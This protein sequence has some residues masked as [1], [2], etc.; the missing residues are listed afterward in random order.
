ME[1]RNRTVMEMARR[2]LKEMKLPAVLW[3]EAVRHTVYVLKKF[4]TR[5]LTGVTPYEAWYRK[6]PDIGHIRV[7]GCLGHIKVPS[8]STQ[9]LDDRSMCVINLGREP[10]PKLIAYIVL[11]RNKYMSV[12]MSL[13]KK[14]NLGHGKVK[15]KARRGRW[16]FL[17]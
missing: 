6:K 1:L 9:K 10:A 2:N 3:G 5:A 16:I 11:R 7:F 4:S 12:M 8:I 15:M 14:I 17:L 13:L